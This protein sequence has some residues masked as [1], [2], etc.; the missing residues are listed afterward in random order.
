MIQSTVEGEESYVI[1]S[2]NE[3][4]TDTR[5]IALSLLL[6]YYKHRKIKIHQ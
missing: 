3:V 6:L 2:L 4:A 5:R 1:N